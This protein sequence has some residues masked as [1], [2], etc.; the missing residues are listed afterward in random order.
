MNIIICDGA[1]HSQFSA[2]IKNQG[3][4]IIR[5]VHN[6]SSLYDLIEFNG[7]GYFRKDTNN[8]IKLNYESTLVFYSGVIYEMGRYI[9]KNNYHS[10][11][12]TKDYI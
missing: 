1:N 11:D 2:K 4:T 12:I 8:Y 10:L 5:A 3:E 7:K 9:L 6:F